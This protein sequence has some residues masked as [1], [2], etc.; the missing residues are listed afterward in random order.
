MLQLWGKW[1][2]LS[3]LEPVRQTGDSEW[4]KESKERREE[5][6]EGDAESIALITMWMELLTVMALVAGEGVVGA[7]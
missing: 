6:N 7:W 5:V 4:K 1:C 2:W 3:L